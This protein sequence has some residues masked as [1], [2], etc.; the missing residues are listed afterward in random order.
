MKYLYYTLHIFY[1]KV[2]KVQNYDT[3]HFSISLVLAT[4]ESF[5]VFSII[6]LLLLGQLESK[7]SYIKWI[8]ISFI[9]FAFTLNWYY[10]K[11]KKKEIIRNISSKPKKTRNVIIILS[12]LFILLII[13]FWF[14]TGYLVRTHNLSL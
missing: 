9:A 4:L 10:Y 11:P 6:D 12:T 8:P 1:T 13:S 14:Y 7:I 2:I 3:P 5:I